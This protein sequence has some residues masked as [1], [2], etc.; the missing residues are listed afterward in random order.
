MAKVAQEVETDD[1]GNLVLPRGVLGTSK[2]HVRYKVK[3]RG[4]EI[5]LSPAE[6]V[7]PKD[8]PPKQRAEEFRKWAA[9][10]P[11]APHLPDEALKREN[12][13]D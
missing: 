10:L 12:W 3:R 6:E 5:R 2:P 11:R 9:S 8:L 1:H 7:L 4:R 13:Y